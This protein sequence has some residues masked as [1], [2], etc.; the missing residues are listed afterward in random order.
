M[1]GHMGPREPTIATLVWMDDPGERQAC[2]GRAGRVPACVCGRRVSVCVQYRSALR[3]NLFVRS[4]CSY[5]SALPSLTRWMVCA[6]ERFLPSIPSVIHLD[7]STLGLLVPFRSSFDRWRGPDPSDNRSIGNDGWKGCG[8]VP[9]TPMPSHL[10]PI[11]CLSFFLLMGWSS[12]WFLP[13]MGS[14]TVSLSGGEGTW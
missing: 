14:P 11:V 10:F 3:L 1:N 13:S 5:A 6:A 7:R 9:A 2:K 12:F 8:L 4:S